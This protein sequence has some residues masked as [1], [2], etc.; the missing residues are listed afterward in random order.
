MGLPTIVSGY[1]CNDCGHIF[2]IPKDSAERVT[3]MEG[4]FQMPVI[5]LPAGIVLA[6]CN[7]HGPDAYRIVGS[8]ERIGVD[9][10]SVHNVHEFNPDMGSKG[11][12]TNVLNEQN[13]GVIIAEFSKG[14]YRFIDSESRE[15]FANQFDSELSQE[16]KLPGLI[17]D[18]S[19][20]LDSVTESERR[21][22]DRLLRFA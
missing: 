13:A 7:S 18:P 11:L 16:L 3:L 2:E 8:P 12:F 15:W 14:K 10:Y 9:H 1:R 5:S 4:H 19:K 6:V 17:L 22:L 21:G 20:V